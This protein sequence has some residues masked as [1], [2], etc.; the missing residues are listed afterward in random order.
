[1]GHHGAPCVTKGHKGVSRGTNGH[2]GAPRTIGLIPCNFF[3]CILRLYILFSCLWIIVF[4]SRPKVKKAHW[5]NPLQLFVLNHKVVCYIF[6]SVNNCLVFLVG[7]KGTKAHW[8]NHLPII[9]NNCV[10]CFRVK[11]VSKKS[12]CN[13]I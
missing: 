1:M 5:I 8:F 2:Q 10:K 7:Q 11:M 4:C 3:G 9:K 13:K 12:C 6:M